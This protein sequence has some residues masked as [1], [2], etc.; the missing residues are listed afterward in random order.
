MY[1]CVRV[2]VCGCEAC[3]R[4]F[5]INSAHALWGRDVNSRVTNY[6]DLGVPAANQETLR[7]VGQSYVDMCHRGGTTGREMKNAIV[8][9]AGTSSTT[10]HEQLPI[11]CPGCFLSYEDTFG[12]ENGHYV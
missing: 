4:M 6:R 9:M 12:Q 2:C 5:V 10:P 1:A 3:V 11:T 7:F 8:S